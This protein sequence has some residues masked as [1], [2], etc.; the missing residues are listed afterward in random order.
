MNL[1]VAEHLSA[2]TKSTI[3]CITS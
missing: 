2:E 1:E 3:T